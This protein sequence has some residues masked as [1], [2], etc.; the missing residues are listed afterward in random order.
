MTHEKI[1]TRPDG[2]RVKICAW[3][4]LDLIDGFKYYNSIKV[5][6]PGKRKFIDVDTRLPYEM[7]NATFK[8]RM[9]FFQDENLKFASKDEVHQTYMELWHKLKPE[10]L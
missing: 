2:N 9:Q 8:E 5:S 1:F 7:R 4:Y 6:A 3:V 10:T